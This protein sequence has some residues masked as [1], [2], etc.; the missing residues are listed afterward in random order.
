VPV[1][2]VE[3]PGSEPKH[4]D[5]DLMPQVLA[6]VRKGRMTVPLGNRPG[7][8]ELAGLP[9]C[10]VATLRANGENLHRVV[11][12]AICRTSGWALPV[13]YGSFD[14][15]TGFQEYGKEAETLR[16]GWGLTPTSS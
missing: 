15:A 4:I 10:S 1:E 2:V 9:W 12:P 6:A 3:W 13:L 11:G 7:L 16:K 5:L 8:A 14:P